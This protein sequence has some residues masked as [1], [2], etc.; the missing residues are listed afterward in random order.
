LKLGVDNHT[1]LGVDNHTHYMMAMTPESKNTLLDPYA[2]SYR[3]VALN[4]RA[5]SAQAC[6]LGC[7]THMCEVTTAS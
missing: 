3:D 7:D 2:H 6:T 5:L 4:V 1:Q